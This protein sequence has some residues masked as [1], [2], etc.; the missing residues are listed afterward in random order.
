MAL[1]DEVGSLTRE[2]KLRNVANAE[3][4]LFKVEVEEEE[5]DE[6]NDWDECDGRPSR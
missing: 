1:L 6:H 5:G 2:R 4:E 3:E